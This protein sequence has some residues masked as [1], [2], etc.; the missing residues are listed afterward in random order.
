MKPS[1]PNNSNGSGSLTKS[2]RPRSKIILSGLALLLVTLSCRTVVPPGSPAETPTHSA[3][4]ASTPSRSLTAT[5]PG[6]GVSSPPSSQPTSAP[7]LATPQ[8][9]AQPTVASVPTTSGPCTSDVCTTAGSFLLARPIGPGG[10]N[11]IETAYRFGVLRNNNIGVHHGVDF[12]NSTGTPVLAAADGK[13]I[14]AG[15]DLQ[16]VYALHP[17]TYGNLVILKH[18]LPGIPGPV[19]TLYGQLS[20]VAVKVGDQVQAGQTIGQVG[21]SGSV[22]GS[23]LHFEVRVGE[24]TYQAVRN[25]ELWLAPLSDDNGQPRGAIAGRVLD[26]KGNPVP[27]SNIVVERQGGKGQPA[28]ETFYL[29]TYAEKRLWGQNPWEES[30]AAGD[31]P[32]G[33]YKITF[34]LGSHYE[35]VVQV[36][37]GQ[38]TE[39]TFHVP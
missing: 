36:Q 10:R 34:R 25:P 16:T 35:Q 8:P 22:K 7:L 33:S 27:I 11:T 14:V 19:Y 13:V 9:G 18:N 26:A 32:A 4:Q 31:L 5:A 12:L 17:D 3:P 37:P 6:P 29:K 38:L 1:Q 21:S 30:F 15:N 2:R 28:V 24:N 20:Q 23:T 39:V